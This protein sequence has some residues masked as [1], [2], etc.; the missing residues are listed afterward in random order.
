[1]IL[2]D[3]DVAVDVLRNHAP[4]VAWLQGLGATPVAL[5]GLVVMELLQ[6]CRNKTE[7]QRVE[8]FRVPFKLFWP[9]EPDC[10]RAMKDFAAFYL[11]HNLGL[12]DALIAHT[13]VGVNTSLATFN[14][15]HYAVISGLSTIQPY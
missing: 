13:A 15:K 3:T 14:V 4:A 6:G 8:Q 10:D 5:P 11:S 1:V 7:Q 2:L 9:S 12:L